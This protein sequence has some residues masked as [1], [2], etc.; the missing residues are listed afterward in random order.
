MP[1]RAKSEPLRAPSVA[2]QASSLS[3]VRAFLP[4][5]HTG[6]AR[7]GF[8]EAN[9]PWGIEGGIPPST[10]S[11]L[12]LLLLAVQV[13]QN[14]LN[15]QVV[16][17]SVA[18]IAQSDQSFDRFLF[19]FFLWNVDRELVKNLFCSHVFRLLCFRDLIRAQ[20]HCQSVRAR[21][22]RID[23]LSTLSLASIT[24]S[25]YGIG[26]FCRPCESPLVTQNQKMYGER[27]WS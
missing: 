27:G 3:K 4:F 21:K 2:L 6:G 20:G 19:L 5:P 18:L 14:R 22:S 15:D 23:P 11:T 24:S 26:A 8:V 9:E 7:A 10:V 13:L 16:N 17:R 1:R 12:G 25:L